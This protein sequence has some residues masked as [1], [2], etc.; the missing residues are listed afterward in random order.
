MSRPNTSDD[1][2][3]PLLAGDPPEEADGNIFENRRFTIFNRT[4]NL[5]HLVAIIVCILSLTAIGLS[6]AAIGITITLL[7]LEPI[8]MI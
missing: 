1:P 6:V 7:V 8:L 5:F 2:H 3:A 4:L